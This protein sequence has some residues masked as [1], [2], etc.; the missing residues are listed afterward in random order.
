MNQRNDKEEPC[1]YAVKTR[2][3]HEAKVMNALADRGLEVFYPTISVMNR[4]KD[5]KKM[6]SKPLFPGYLFVR[7]VMAYESRM[8]ILKTFGV[9]GII[10]NASNCA[11]PIPD[12]Q[13][14]AVMKL[15]DSGY[16]PRPHPYLN[17]GDKVVVKEGS[18][19]GAT[20]YFIG[21]GKDKGK[22]VVS[23]D[24]LGRSLEVDI[25]SYMVEQF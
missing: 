8:A 19:L 1:W 10:E 13:V 9:A 7:C 18:M 2:S 11:A 21:V 16:A 15:V 6:V 25:D 3:R 23:V 12:E 20:G 24:M 4:W 17:E 22:L 5:R 14:E